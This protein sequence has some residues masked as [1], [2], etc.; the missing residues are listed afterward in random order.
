MM[1]EE[2]ATHMIVH[3]KDCT[4]GYPVTYFFV[5]KSRLPADLS[6]FSCIDCDAV[7]EE[8]RLKKNGWIVSY[9]KDDQG[10][11]RQRKSYIT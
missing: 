6:E 4:C 1:S 9:G 2:T 10:L 5:E 11:V 7:I 8:N 3:E